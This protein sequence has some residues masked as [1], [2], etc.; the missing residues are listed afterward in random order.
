MIRKPVQDRLL[1]GEKHFRWRGGDVSRLENLSDVVFAFALTL[2]VASADMPAT[3]E[4]LLDTLW[5]FPVFVVCF[6]LL[7]MCWY[8]HYLHHRRYGFE[9]LLSVVLNGLF[10]LLIL[11]YVYPLKFLFSILVA[12]AMGRD[13][14]V[15]LADGSVV[16]PIRFG[17]MQQL[18]I[19]YGAGFA[20]VFL[21]LS[22]MEWRAYRRREELD[23]D[24]VEI[25]I[26]RSTVASHFLSMAVGLTSI[27]IAASNPSWSALSGWFYGSLFPLQ[28]A[29]GYLAGK[30]IEKL[31]AS[32]EVGP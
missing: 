2:I 17:D 11:F 14:D 32:S 22:L 27:A 16:S 26:T 4:G 30:K 8:S 7:T 6:L 9:D 3:F 5:Q 13:L 25:L 19:F 23:L 31:T 10:L 18:M 21:L 28:F 12:A 20:G 1:R 24:E 29:N 15:T